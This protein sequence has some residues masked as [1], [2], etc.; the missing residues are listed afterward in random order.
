MLTFANSTVW[1]V[2]LFLILALRYF[3]LT[4]FSYQF[5]VVDQ[6]IAVLPRVG[7]VARE[8]PRVNLLTVVQVVQRPRE[9]VDRVVD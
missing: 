1:N 4:M 7:T 5:H 9:E 8:R 2:P 3:G 6:R